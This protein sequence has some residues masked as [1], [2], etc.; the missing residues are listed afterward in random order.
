MAK[1]WLAG[2]SQGFALPLRQ[3]IALTACG[4][5]SA[6]EGWRAVGG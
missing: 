3:L 2:Y 1:R 4:L 6:A 5:R